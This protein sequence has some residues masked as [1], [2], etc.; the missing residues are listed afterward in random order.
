MVPKRAAMASAV[1]VES[2]TPAKLV[3]I[4][5]SVG[6]NSLVI[7]VGR[8]ARVR[9][10][11]Q[12][13]GLRANSLAFL[14]ARGVRL[15]LGMKVGR[16]GWMGGAETWDVRDG[17]TGVLVLSEEACTLVLMDGDREVARVPIHL[18][19]NAMNVLRP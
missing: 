9:V 8:V 3:P 10:E 13:P 16:G 14:D 19:P 2:A 18:D 7:T 11:L 15:S 5:G 1:A 4:D 6:R 12:T 17:R